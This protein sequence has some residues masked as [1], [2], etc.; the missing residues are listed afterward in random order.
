MSHYSLSS[1]SQQYDGFVW[2][3]QT[4]AITPLPGDGQAGEEETYPFGL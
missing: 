2:L 4:H 3:D 1:L